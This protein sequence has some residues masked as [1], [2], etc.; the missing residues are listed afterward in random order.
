MSISAMAMLRQLIHDGLLV[1]LLSVPL[2]ETYATLDFIEVMLLIQ[3][4]EDGCE[5]VS[6]LHHSAIEGEQR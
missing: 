1:G 5:A 6:L 4:F 3:P 2:G